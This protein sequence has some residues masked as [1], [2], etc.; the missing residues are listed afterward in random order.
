MQSGNVCLRNVER[1]SQHR[2]YKSE[3]LFPEHPF[4]SLGDI[5][6]KVVALYDSLERT[7]WNHI[8]EDELNYYFFVL[9]W[10]LRRDQTKIL[11]AIE[12]DEI[13]GLMLIYRNYVVQLRGSRAAV[14]MLLDGLTL[15]KVE[16]QAP[17]DCKDLVLSKYVGPKIREEMM[18]MSLMKGQEHIQVT[19]T[20]V[21]LSASDAEEV[22]DLVRRADPSWWGETTLENMQKSL[23]DAFWLGIRQ[24][25]K[26]VS[27]GMTRLVDF[28]SNIG[29][30]ATEEKYRNKGYATSIVSALVSEILKISSTAMIHVISNNAPAVRAYSKVGFRPYR[31]YLS[32]RT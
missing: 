32:I 12:D 26:I 16:L 25:H 4:S 8:K 28:A 7:F 14:K 29:V 3:A 6:L 24:D 22:L 15:E 9:D 21:R 23:Q 5:T 19:T 2:R 10:K 1:H 17:L 11:M 18:L 30:A 27:V 31:T 20:P 13:E